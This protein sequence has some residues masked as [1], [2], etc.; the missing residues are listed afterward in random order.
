MHACPLY[1][2]S[3]KSSQSISCELIPCN[4]SDHL[5]HMPFSA[6]NSQLANSTINATSPVALRYA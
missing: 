1:I 3:A 2:F 6:Y 4:I 5:M